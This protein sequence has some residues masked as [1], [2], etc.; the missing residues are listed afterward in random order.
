MKPLDYS[1]A[2]KL[3]IV[4]RQ[5]QVEDELC[6]GRYISSQLVQHLLN[7]ER[8]GAGSLGWCCYFVPY[9]QQNP[10]RMLVYLAQGGY[11]QRKNNPPIAFHWLCALMPLPIPTVCIAG[12]KRLGWAAAML[13]C[14]LT[15]FSAPWDCLQLV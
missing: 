15:T 5:M 14:S 2:L 1:P 9:H 3:F 12:D 13:S 4:A 10:V 7:L 11:H 8:L 6:L